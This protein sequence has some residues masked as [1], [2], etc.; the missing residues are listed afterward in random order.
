MA[1]SP[2]HLNLHCAEDMEAA[3]ALV[4][5]TCQNGGSGS[6]VTPQQNPL[7]M[8]AQNGTQVRNAAEDLLTQRVGLS[9]GAIRPQ[10]DMH[11]YQEVLRRMVGSPDYVDVDI[12]HVL[13][14]RELLPADQK[15]QVDLVFNAR[16]FHDWNR[17]AFPQK[18]LI[19][20]DN[21][22]PTT[23]AGV[24][25]LSG[26]CADL[27]RN[28][29]TKPE[30]LTI[31]WFCG[32]HIDPVEPQTAVGGRAMVASLIDQ[33]LRRHH[34]DMKKVPRDINTASVQ[35]GNIRTLIKLLRWLIRRLP[36]DITLLCIIDGLVMFERR[37]PRES[38]DGLFKSSGNLQ[39]SSNT[40]Y[41]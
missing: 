39:R 27:V 23:I 16:L 11:D 24:S 36:A 5:L 2:S 38:F 33:L 14:T 12:S 26:F 40:V 1:S 9:P 28:V 25:P 15:A 17:S 21:N 31:V 4:S 8:S 34:F 30:F 22:K 41:D 19:Q 35:L 37:V 29:E 7:S 13:H 3:Q 18:L 10:L 6:S 20:W 32:L